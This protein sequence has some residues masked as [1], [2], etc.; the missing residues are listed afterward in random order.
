MPA[1]TWS[2]WLALLLVSVA[3]LAQPSLASSPAIEPTSEPSTNELVLL[4]LPAKLVVKIQDFDQLPAPFLTARAAV[5]IDLKTGAI[6]FARDHQEELAPASVTKLLTALVARDVYFLDQVLVVDQN[7]F[8]PGNSIAFTA[9][10]EVSVANLIKALLI[11]SGNDAAEIL[12]LNHPEGY[13]GFINQM[14][15]HASALGLTN[16]HFLNP[17]GLDAPGHHSSALDIS[18]LFNQ[19]LRDPYL[20]LVLSQS[21]ADIVDSSGLQARRLYNTNQLLWAGRAL[22]GKT[23]TTQAAGEVLTTLIEVEGQKVIVTVFGSQDRYQDTLSLSSWLQS[24]YMWVELSTT[25][26]VN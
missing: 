13:Q 17:S 1:F 19:A 18:I 26:L 15:E 22:A 2:Q 12:A 9:G 25:P 23:G 21:V 5:A 20:N 3:I 10:E 24:A 6:L 11:Q 14:N 4:E 7:L 8:V 16:S